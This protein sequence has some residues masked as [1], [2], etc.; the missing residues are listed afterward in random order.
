MAVPGQYGKFL[1]LGDGGERAKRVDVVSA[2]LPTR[3][4]LDKNE[5][6]GVP[7]EALALVLVL[8]DRE[9]TSTANLQDSP[10]RARSS[11]RGTNTHPFPNSLQ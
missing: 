11:A 9:R 10:Y 3:R 7:E 6:F 1:N 2:L 5:D 8:G 4:T